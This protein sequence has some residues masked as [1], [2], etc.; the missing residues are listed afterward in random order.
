MA[1]T[2]GKRPGGD[3]LAVAREL[4]LGRKT[5]VLDIVRQEE[6]ERAFWVSGDLYVPADHVL[7]EAARAAERSEEGGADPVLVEALASW[8]AGLGDTELRFRAGVEGIGSDLIGPLPLQSGLMRAAVAGREEFELLKQLG[9][10]ESRLVANTTARELD[11]VGLATEEAFFL[12]RLDRPA[13]VKEL[14]RQTDLDRR[15]ALAALCRLQAAALVVSA[16]RAVREEGS[17]LLSAGMVERFDERI[18]DSLERTPLALGAEAHR[19]RLGQLMGRFG[20]MTYY[21]LLGVGFA[22]S[23]G[24]IHDAY[25][26]LARTVHPSH[27]ERLGLGGGE[28]GLRLLFERTTEAYLVLSDQDRRRAYLERVGSEGLTLGGSVEAGARDDEQRELAARNYRKARSLAQREEYH[29]AIELLHQAVRADPRAEYYRLLADC[30]A[31]N[32]N[33]MRKAIFNY[34]KAA[35]LCP[36]DPSIRVDLARAYERVGNPG[37]ARIEYRAALEIMPGYPEATEGLSRIEGRSSKSSR[38]G[39]LKRWLGRLRRR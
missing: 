32:P 17:E 8:L 13:T 12:S 27:A 9:G 4:H 19:E 1:E 7:G 28:A 26:A 25:L 14:L 23:E 16:H 35:Q 30:Q 39:R 33:W 10:E 5:G 36:E 18:A 15:T 38:E 31:V 34:S 6:R 20:E 21:E 11:D 24:E 22:A 2:D 37:G 29:F 3:A